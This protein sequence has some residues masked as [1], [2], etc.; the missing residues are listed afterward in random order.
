[1]LVLQMRRRPLQR[2]SVYSTQILSI[3]IETEAGLQVA[4][5]WLLRRRFSLVVEEKEPSIMV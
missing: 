3:V 1:L 5:I 2:T 4:R